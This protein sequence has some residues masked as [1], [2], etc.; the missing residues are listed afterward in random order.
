MNQNNETSNTKTLNEE[1]RPVV[2]LEDFYAVSNHG[3]VKSLVGNGRRKELIMSQRLNTKGK[4]GYLQVS[5]RRGLNKLKRVCV[6][7]LVAMAFV[8]N[9]NP[10]EYTIVNHKDENRLNNHA[11]NLEWCNQKYNVCYSFD[12]HRKDRVDLIKKGRKNT[13]RNSLS[14]APWWNNGTKNKRCWSCPGD[15][16]SMGCIQQRNTRTRTGKNWDAMLEGKTRMEMIR[17]IYDN[18]KGGYRHRLLE[19]FGI[20][21]TEQEKR[22]HYENGMKRR[23]RK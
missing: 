9:P 21:L 20:R 10:N 5:F 23:K 2:G 12:R 14:Y 4:V 1:W 22:E 7:R 6:H 8:E 17:I 16:W 18:S 3:R 19:R 13:D 15:G 11:D